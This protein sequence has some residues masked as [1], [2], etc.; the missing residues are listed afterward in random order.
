MK[1]TIWL[2]HCVH[3]YF[4]SIQELGQSSKVDL[5][6]KDKVI[7][8]RRQTSSETG[9]FLRTYLLLHL[10]TMSGNVRCVLVLRA[11]EP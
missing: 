8:E 9:N 1:P 4:I 5:L 11:E 3:N 6:R 2:F 7:F 10:F